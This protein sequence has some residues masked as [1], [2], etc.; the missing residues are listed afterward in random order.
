MATSYLQRTVGTPTNAQKYTYSF[1]VKRCEL[2][3]GVKEAFL[4]DGYADGSN[5]AKIA[6]QSTEQLEIW[7]KDGGSNTFALNPPRKFRDVS[8]FYHIVLSVDTTQATA[9]D[10]VKLYINGV[11]ETNLGSTTYPSQNDA[12]NT[13]NESGTTFSIQAYGGNASSNDYR[14]D[15]LLT[16]IHFTDGYAY[17]AST[18]GETDS[19]SGIWKPKTA[20]SVTYGNNGFFLKFENSG[21]MGTDSSGNSNTFTVSGTLTQNV[22][23]PSNV[24]TILNRLQRSRKNTNNGGDY[25]FKGNLTFDTS[26]ANGMMAVVLGT[27]GVQSGKYY[28]EYKVITNTRLEVGISQANVMGF[29]DPYYDLQTFSTIAMNSSGNIKGR[30]I[31]GSSW[32]D[33]A[34]GTSNTTNDIIGL[35][36]DM[37]NKALYIHKNGTYL[38]NGTAVGVPTSGSSRTGSLI[39]PFAGSRDDYIPDGE[40][41]FPYVHDVSTT[42]VAKAEFNF[43]QGYFGTTA[44]A[45]AGTSPSGGGIFEFDCPNG[46]QA[47]CTKGINSF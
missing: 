17:D 20:P 18:F 46:Y 4:L 41:I 3:D 9:S 43:G 13:I 21:A 16:H 7:N 31:G 5:R 40:F 11:Q 12:N 14:L 47:L 1:W 30:F 39:E 27:M 24:F 26:S 35:A 2:S 8:A 22:D 36:L 34:T 32:D 19:T 6:F 23:T 44:V 33:Y 25:L 15:S 45:S 28:W 38:S 37:D 10:R 29:T 42:G